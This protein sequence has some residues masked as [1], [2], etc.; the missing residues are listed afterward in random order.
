LYGLKLRRE[1]YGGNSDRYYYELLASQYLRD[2]VLSEK[3]SNA[4]VHIARHATRTVPFYIDW[5]ARE[6]IR[7]E[8]IRGIGDLNRFPIVQKN[9]IKNN[10]KRF[11]SCAI[12]PSR[13]FR[14]FTSGTSGSPMTVY[15]DYDS[16]RHHYAFFRRLRSWFGV[17]FG[18]RRATLFGRIAVSSNQ[19][20]PPFWRYDI[21]QHNMLFSSYHLSE[22]NMG[23]YYRKL[24][25]YN[26]EEIISYPS[27]VYLL[28]KYILSKKMEPLRP[29][30]LITTAETLTDLQRDVLS[31]AF[32]CPII[33]QYGSTEMTHFVSQCEHGTY[34]VHPE[35][36]IME[37]LDAGDQPVREGNA[38]SVVCTGLINYAM[39]LIRYRLNDMVALDSGKCS[40][41]RNF[42]IIKEIFGRMDDL[43][44]TPEGK[45][46][47]R[48]DPVFKGLTGIYETQIIQH[49]I[50]RIELRIVLDPA[51]RERILRELEGELR[52][53]LGSEVMI[54][55]MV[56]SEIPK[57][58]N[59]KFRAVVSK[60]KHSVNAEKG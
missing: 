43:I 55:M 28:A 18:G 32:L 44:I 14:L 6:K 9:D 1:R 16:R 51:D 8:D 41:G 36:G 31:R 5:A 21:A 30:V 48:M 56:V 54:D 34:H 53:R 42:P 57:D 11:I 15:C 33:D 22:E 45:T 49:A 3:V 52:K 39:P 38:G 4:F 50:D 24:K 19:K 7:E 10:P 27:S 2:E 23:H 26:P 59:G 25:S 12:P 58:K 13:L 20:H 40:C 17:D 37:V 29:K 47:G 60:L 35:H 46:I